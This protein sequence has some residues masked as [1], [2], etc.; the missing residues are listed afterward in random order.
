MRR[1][2]RTEIGA[3]LTFRVNAHTDAR[4]RRRR[5]TVGR[6]PGLNPPPARV[7]R[8]VATPDSIAGMSVPSI[9]AYQGPVQVPLAFKNAPSQNNW[10]GAG[11]NPPNWLRR[12]GF[13]D[14]LP[15][16]PP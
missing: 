6:V 4:G 3:Q 13:T 10:I 16:C 14:F 2:T 8:S 5:F 1:S 15:N 9:T 7:S 11:V 12:S